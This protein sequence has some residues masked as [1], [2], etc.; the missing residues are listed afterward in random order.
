[1][2]PPGGEGE[3]EHICLSKLPCDCLKGIWQSLLSQLF[4]LLK[5]IIIIIKKLKTERHTQEVLQN[6]RHKHSWVCGLSPWS[7]NTFSTQACPC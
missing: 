2:L 5:I 4:L 3:P 1:M 6:T 7:L